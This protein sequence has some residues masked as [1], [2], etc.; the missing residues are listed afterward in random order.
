MSVEMKGKGREV[1]AG[2]GE[3][4]LSMKVF[5][6]DWRRGGICML[7]LHFCFA[8]LR[9]VQKS[10]ERMYRNVLCRE[11]NAECAC[12]VFFFPGFVALVR[13]PTCDKE[14]KEVDGIMYDRKG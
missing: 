8:S 5:F 7:L 1:L 13:D 6:T 2:G 14:E 9:N 12:A 3:V 4:C 11:K 10:G